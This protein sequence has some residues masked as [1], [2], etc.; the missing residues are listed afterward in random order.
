MIPIA[1]LTAWGLGVVL[2]AALVAGGERL[3]RRMLRT[4]ST[5]LDEETR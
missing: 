5:D 2:V 3:E 1:V 4:E